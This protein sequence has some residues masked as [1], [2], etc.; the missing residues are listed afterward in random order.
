MVKFNNYYFLLAVALFGLE[1][2]IGNSMH[3]N[4][5]RPYGGDFLVVIF[6]YCLVKSFINFPVLLTVAWV[7]I[8]AYI[9][10]VSQYFHLVRLLGLQHSKV[11]RILLGTSFSFIDLGMYT[12]GVL[13]VIVVENLKDSLKNF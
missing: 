6:L 3:D 7:L 5:I 10:E 8:F 1:F 11:A 4:I 12:L 2:Y 13:V 9:V